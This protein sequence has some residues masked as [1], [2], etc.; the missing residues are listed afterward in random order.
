MSKDTSLPRT[1]ESA[2]KINE[3]IA[4]NTLNLWAEEAKSGNSPIAANNL[5]V[6]FIESVNAGSEP[7][8]EITQYLASS[9]QHYLQEGS[10]NLEQILGL[11][12]Q[13]GKKNNKPRNISYFFEYLELKREGINYDEILSLLGDKHCKSP[14]AIESAITPLLKEFNETRANITPGE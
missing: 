7:P 12:P 13:R 6:F 3:I 4:S 8:K 14:K 2:H 5:L 1:Q 11:K 9:F 10:K